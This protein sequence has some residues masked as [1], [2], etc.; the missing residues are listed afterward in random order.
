[1]PKREEGRNRALQAV[2]IERALVGQAL[3]ARRAM[4]AQRRQDAGRYV[5]VHHSIRK[6]AG[7]Q[8]ASLRKGRGI[9]GEDSVI[10]GVES[11]MFVEERLQRRRLDV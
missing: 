9:R 10:R 5:A 4:G 11:K 6:S 7:G 2:R 3:G 8:Y 1:M